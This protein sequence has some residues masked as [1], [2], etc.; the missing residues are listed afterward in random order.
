MKLATTMTNQEA[1]DTIRQ[2]LADWDNLTA[3]QRAEA[4][5]IAAEQAAI[6]YRCTGKTTRTGRRET[7]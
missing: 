4:Q 5:A 3:E 7:K 2:M 1:Q 6:R